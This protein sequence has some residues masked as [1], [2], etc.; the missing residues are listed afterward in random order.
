MKGAGRLKCGAMVF[1]FHI[2]LKKENIFMCILCQ[3]G[4][5]KSLISLPYP[6]TVS[7][8]TVRPKAYI[9]SYLNM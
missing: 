6:H 1:C 5:V 4:K 2:K 9:I 7:S 3:G 8:E